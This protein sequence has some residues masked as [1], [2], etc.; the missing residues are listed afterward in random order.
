[1]STTQPDPRAACLEMFRLLR[2]ETPDTVRLGEIVCT[3]IAGGLIPWLQRQIYKTFFCSMAPCPDPEPVEAFVRSLSLA[4]T[5][6]RPEHRESITAQP[7]S[8]M[9]FGPLEPPGTRWLRLYW[10]VDT[11][12]AVALM[13]GAT[14]T[15]NRLA[16]PF[17]LKVLVNTS[18]RRRDAAV[19]YVPCVVWPEVRTAVAALANEA[20][21]PET[22]LFTKTLRPGLGVAEDPRTGL[23]FGLERSGLAARALARSYAL[24]HTNAE[25]QYADLAAEFA[26]EGLSLERAYLNAGSADVYRL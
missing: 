3:G 7:G 8:Y 23:S 26:A 2:I 1:M 9:A 12:G 4:N 18:I 25:E 21:A 6:G 22:P 15:L 5:G 19:L 17:R 11:R 24:G 20:L 16:I 13:A 10:N 14:G